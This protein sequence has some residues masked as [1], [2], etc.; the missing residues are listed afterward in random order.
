MILIDSILDISSFKSSRCKIELN[1]KCGSGNTRPIIDVWLAGSQVDKENGTVPSASYWSGSSKKAWIKNGEMVFSFVHIKGDDWLFVSAAE[2]ITS[3]PN[4][5]AA[6]NILQQYQPYFGRLILH[7]HKKTQICANFWNTIANSKNSSGTCNCYVKE[8]L[9]SI[10]D[11]VSFP[12]YNN[13]QLTYPQLDIVLNGSSMS[14][15][16]TALSIV[17]GIYL[18][19]DTNTGKLYVGSAYG[20]DGIAQRWGTYLSTSHGGN[21]KLIDLYNKNGKE[22][23]DKYFNFTLLEHFDMGVPATE[24]IQREN[25]WMT[26]LDTRVHGYNN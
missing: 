10:Y 3:T 12:G 23:F 2:I 16:K 15:Y 9:P 17:Q 8:I 11:G 14:S 22:Y 25:D 21:K 7:H 6:V 24:I 19:T 18:L 26:K 4:S 1:M 13:I 5:H 20:S